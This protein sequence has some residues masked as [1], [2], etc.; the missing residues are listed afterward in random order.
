MHPL[1]YKYFNRRTT[2]YS[3]GLITFAVKLFPS[4]TLL[5]FAVDIL[6]TLLKLNDLFRSSWKTSLRKLRF[7]FIQFA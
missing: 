7:V 1:H 2:I 4:G 3:N 5:L 6:S